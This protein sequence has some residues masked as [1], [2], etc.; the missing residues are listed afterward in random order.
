MRNVVKNWFPWNRLGGAEV[1]KAYFPNGVR[2]SSGRGNARGCLEGIPRFYRFP[3][4]EC[5]AYSS[6]GSELC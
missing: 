6:S 4:K 1:R 5:Q 3:D 2:V